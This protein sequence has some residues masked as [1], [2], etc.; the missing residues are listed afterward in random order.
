MRFHVSAMAALLLLV[1]AACGSEASG[2]PRIGPDTLPDTL[3]DTAAVTLPAGVYELAGMEPSL[4][5]TDLAP[6]A[7]IIGTASIV[8]LG[9]TYHNSH[10]FFTMKSRVIRHMV[11]DLGFRAVAWE[12]G[13]REARVA[14]DY[15]AS[16]AG[17]PEAAMHSL[18]PVWWDVSVRDLL[19]WMCEYNQAHPADPVVL[20]GFDVQEPWFNRPALA[21]FVAR[22]APAA[23]SLLDPLASCVGLVSFA[24]DAARTGTGTTSLDDRGARSVGAAGS[25][26]QLLPD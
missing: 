1:L 16:C 19:R 15:V 4:P 11:E 23:D 6:L 2:P 12:T 8:A 25:A 24:G 17:T 22:A 21:S 9:E 10:G 3:P 14:A 13:W 5:R 7:G 18:Y 26:A 20:Y